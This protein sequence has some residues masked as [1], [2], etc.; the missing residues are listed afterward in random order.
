M[1]NRRDLYNGKIMSTI[2]SILFYIYVL[3][4]QIYEYTVPGSGLVEC[5]EVLATVLGIF[6]VELVSLFGEVVGC[7]GS[8]AANTLCKSDHYF[9]VY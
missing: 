4:A 9:S 2:Q 7:T 5:I 3:T 8:G 1:L 6:V